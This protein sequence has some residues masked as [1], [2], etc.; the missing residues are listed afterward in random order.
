MKLLAAILVSFL[1]WG[2]LEQKVESR[3]H[4]SR[5]VG[6]SLIQYRI[7]PICPYDTC[8]RC[9]NAEVVLKLVVKKSGTVKQL[10]AVQAGNSR[11]AEAALDAVK[12]WR[13]RFR[14]RNAS[15]RNAGRQMST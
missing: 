9:A 14:S 8:S 5:A 2:D 1:I 6:D 7:Q 15:K 3:V 11:L 13:Y 12:R 4:L 10:T